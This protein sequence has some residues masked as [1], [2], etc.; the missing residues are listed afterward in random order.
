M[1]P[2]Q[3]KGKWMQFNAE[4]TQQ[5]S[6]FP[7]VDLPQSEGSYDKFVGTIQERNDKKKDDLMKGADQWQKKSAPEAWGSSVTEWMRFTRD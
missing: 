6:Q 1:N 5:W 3:V 7:D 4:L 2:D